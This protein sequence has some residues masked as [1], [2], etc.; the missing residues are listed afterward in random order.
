MSHSSAVRRPTSTRALITRH[1][2]KL[3]AVSAVAALV[4]GLALSGS[5]ATAAAA[6]GSVATQLRASGTSGLQRALDQLVED[7]A[8]GAL[9]Y[10]YDRGHVTA[11]QSGLA[12]IAAGTPMGPRD[13]FR[14]GSLT[15]TYVSTAVLQLVAHHR[16]DLSDPAS[17]YLPGLLAGKPRITVRELLNH[18]SG[19]YDFNNDPRVLAP[20]LKGDLG[21]VWTPRRLVRIALTHALVAS[22]GTAYHYS[23]TNYLLAGLVVQAVTGRRL[24][25]VLRHRVFS[26]A[27]LRATTFTSSR[28]LPA[29]AAHGYFAFSGDQPTDI[30]SLY[31]YPWASGAAVS[32]APDVA[33]FYRRLLSGRLLPRRLMAAMRTTVDASSE[34][35]PGTAY[36]LGLE[37][38]P[39]PCGAAWG[40]G[41]N[42]PG[43]VTYVY[44]SPNG[45]RQT[46]LLLNEDPAS[47]DPTV[48][49][50]FLRLL[51]R[52]YCR[53]ERTSS[54]R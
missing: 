44:S 13:R 15:K 31:P 11:L 7:G 29:P 34:D 36:G 4:A 49:P 30:T 12:E 32:T 51:N 35:G 25:D 24:G 1:G 48:G 42:F 14:I 45:S 37:R 17:R 39:T 26:R 33:R 6:D 46:V 38:F 8:P 27:N 22:P 10:R 5:A 9:L 3:A 53:S 19:V 54:P 43:Y 23:N 50:D 28:T 41:G 47:F 16:V 52:A 2:S 21:H 40:H 20:Y 18:T